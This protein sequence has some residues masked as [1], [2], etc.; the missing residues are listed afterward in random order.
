MNISDQRIKRFFVFV[1]EIATFRA[2]ATLVIFSAQPLSAGNAVFHAPNLGIL[3]GLTDGFRRTFWVFWNLQTP[4]EPIPLNS[5][6]GNAGK[7]SQ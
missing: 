4:G 6:V 2:I 5:Q 3:D 7:C 1:F